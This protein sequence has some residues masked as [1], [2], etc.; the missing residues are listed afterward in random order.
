VR[1]TG[2]LLAGAT[3]IAAPIPGGPHGATASISA[4]WIDDRDEGPVAQRL[5][6]T[7][8]AIASA[9]P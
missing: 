3:G 2:E 8:A 1:T 5:L 4:V 9:L 7:A 6:A